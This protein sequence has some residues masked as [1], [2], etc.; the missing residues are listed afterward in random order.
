MEQLTRNL[1]HDTQNGSDW[2]TIVQMLCFFVL[3][4]SEVTMDKNNGLS[5]WRLSAFLVCAF[6]A[7]INVGTWVENALEESG[8]C[9]GRGWSSIPDFDL[10][11][12]WT[13]S[14]GATPCAQF[15]IILYYAMLLTGGAYAAFFLAALVAP[16][17]SGQM[18]VPFVMCG[19]YIMSLT[20]WA[21][22]ST[23]HWPMHGLHE[24]T[25]PQ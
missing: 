24:H 22:M 20:Y 25:V 21:S 6:A 9:K 12:Q 10:F 5:L 13:D 8:L 16:R 15:N 14:K 18:L 1:G 19:L 7:G 4:V 17:G 23:M 3:G 2:W 11:N